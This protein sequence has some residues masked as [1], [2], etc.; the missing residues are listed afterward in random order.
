MYGETIPRWKAVLKTVLKIPSTLQWWGSYHDSWHG[1]K[2]E[3]HV[4]SG[5][6]LFSA[7]PRLEESSEVVADI[8]KSF[9]GATSLVLDP[10]I[11]TWTEMSILEI[12]T[13][14]QLYKIFLWPNKWSHK[15]LL[16]TKWKI[17]I[18]SFHRYPMS[19]CRSSG[20]DTTTQQSWAIFWKIQKGWK[21]HL[22]LKR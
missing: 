7:R 3:E 17:W 1:T 19:L 18:L 16:R 22:F 13:S 11:V 9:L 8:S 12:I 14:V 6:L 20:L 4:H 10:V 5:I 2:T 15:A 21:M